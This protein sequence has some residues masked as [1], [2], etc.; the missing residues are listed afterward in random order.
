MILALD[1]L[2]HMKTNTHLKPDAR[3]YTSLIST[4][5]RRDTRASGSKDPD[6][7]FVLFDEM[8]NVY[9]I[10]P[11]GMTY[12]A[13]I[14]VCGRCQRSDLALKGLRMMLREKAKR[15]QQ[16]QN[17][18]NRHR[19]RQNHQNRNQNQNQNQRQ[20]YNNNLEQEVGAWSA[21]IN[22]CGKAGRLDTAIRIFHTM[23]T[24]F[25]VK[26]NI[27]TCGCL[28]D[29]LLKSGKSDY[30][31]EA[32]NVLIYMKK[33]GIQPS[34]VM[35]T[36]LI[37]S[38]GRLA[39]IENKRRGELVLTDFGDRTQGKTGG[40]IRMKALDVYEELLLSLTSPRQPSKSNPQSR[41]PNASNNL[42]KAFLV[43]QEMK[44]TGADP[45][46]ACYNALLRACAESGD[47]PKLRDV[48]RRIEADG[49]T[50]NDTTWK[51][52]LRGAAKARQSAVAEEVW[53]M[54]LLY[55]NVNDD[56]S[57]NVKWVPNVESFVALLASYTLQAS[58]ENVAEVQSHLYGNVVEA[59]LG[60]VEGKEEKGFNHIDINY[61]Q[62]SKRGMSMVMKAA[63]FLIENDFADD[64][65]ESEDYRMYEYKVREIVQDIQELDCFHKKDTLKKKRY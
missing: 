6:L 50:P 26:P 9:N 31:E 55:R 32:L 4:V 58:K 65:D 38:A 16:Q 30:M 61:L 43:F 47:I 20:R 59:Y 28:M 2:S 62:E 8:T 25:G 52:F 42:V 3:T 54:A 56:N 29:C 60:V 22:A 40:D 23:S 57:Y 48:M 41:T 53:N 7:A 45:D 49:L 12:C 51:E 44:A 21:A 36:S 34:E 39:L 1:A 64:D 35:Y 18:Y 14:D 19:H 24:T 10:K 33:E 13:L 17:R 5:A 11:N 46:I 37:A 63:K 27:I 15:Q